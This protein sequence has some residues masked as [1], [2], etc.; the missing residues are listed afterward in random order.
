MTSTSTLG[1]TVV[2]L[3]FDLNRN[4]DGAAQ[5]VQAAITSAGEATAAE[6]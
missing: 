2:T 3:Q 1:S 6:T 5:D 4:I